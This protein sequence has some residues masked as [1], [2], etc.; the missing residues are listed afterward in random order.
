MIWKLE[1]EELT[2]HVVPRDEKIYDLIVTRTG[3]DKAIFSS[4]TTM[5]WGM[6]LRDIH[7]VLLG[8]GFDKDRYQDTLLEIYSA[9]L[10]SALKNIG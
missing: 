2:A 5:Q 1:S 10:E 8:F 9:R 7:T 4:E 3:D 6:S